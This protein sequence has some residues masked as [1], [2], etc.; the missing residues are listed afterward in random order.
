MAGHPRSSR[1]A[2]PVTWPMTTMSGPWPPA[3]RN[4]TANRASGLMPL[5]YEI[6]RAVQALELYYAEAWVL[7]SGLGE[8]WTSADAGG[9]V[10]CATSRAEML[11]A[12]ARRR[13]LDCGGGE[14]PCDGIWG[15]LV[16][17]AS[18]PVSFYGRGRSTEGFGTE[19]LRQW[20]RRRDRNHPTSPASA[21]G[22]VQASTNGSASAL[23]SWT[24][25]WART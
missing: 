20:P 13:L 2:P 3:W 12:H 18:C 14:A 24:L 10:S 9:R 4:W 16:L 17:E 25:A 23:K 15:P 22:P 8:R 11:P 5:E 21:A 7:A 1:T 19:A 6:G